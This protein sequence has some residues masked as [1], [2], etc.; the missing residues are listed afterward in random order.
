[1][2]VFP[3]DVLARCL[4]GLDISKVRTDCWVFRPIHTHHP[5]FADLAP[6]SEVKHG[7]TDYAYLL[8][9]C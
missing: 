8:V 7:E 9:R 1:M 3:L 2:E 5:K 4:S 6:S